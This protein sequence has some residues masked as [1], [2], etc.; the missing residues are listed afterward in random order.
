[1]TS[2]S[3][4]NPR[5]QERPDAAARSLLGWVETFKRHGVEYVH[6]TIRRQ[7]NSGYVVRTVSTTSRRPLVLLRS[8]QIVL[9]PLK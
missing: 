1:M 2:W 8:P 9:G 5:S 3:G 4:S 6:P 7:S